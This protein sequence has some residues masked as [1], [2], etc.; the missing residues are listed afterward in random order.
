MTFG[1]PRI[2]I[3]SGSGLLGR[4]TCA[5][6]FADVILDGLLATAGF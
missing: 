1:L 5:D 6:H 4:M 2:A 3:R